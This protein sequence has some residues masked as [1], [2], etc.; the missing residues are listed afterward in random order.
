MSDLSF[1]QVH[2]DFHTTELIDGVGSR[3]SKEDFQNALKCG[4][5]DSVTLFSKCHHGWS[6]HP[7][8]A[9]AMHPALDFDLLGAQIDAC[10]ELGIR[11][12][13]Y[14]SAGFDHKTCIAHPD[15]MCVD[16]VE[17]IGEPIPQILEHYYRLCF[18]S[19]YLDMLVAQVEEV[20]KKYNCDEIFLDIVGIHPCYCSYCRKILEER[21]KSLYDTEAVMQL[22]EETFYRYTERI[23]N[24]ID[25]HK[26]GLPVFHNS[27]HIR[28]GNRRLAYCNTHLEIES[29]PTGGWG[30][31]HFPLSASY[32]G[33]LG[34]DYIGMTGKFHTTW[35]DFGGYKHPNALKYETS[36]CLANGAGCSIGDQ[37]HPLGMMDKATYRLIGEAYADVEK[38]E[39]YCQDVRRVADIGVLSSEACKAIDAGLLNSNSYPDIGA[40][41]MLT[42]GHYLYEF[43]DMEAD[44]SRYKILVLPDDIQAVGQLE[45]KLKAFVK[46][47]GKLL[48][49][50]KS[51]LDSDNRFTFDFGADFIKKSELSP[52]YLHPLFDTPPFGGA[53]FVVYGDHFDIEVSTGKVLAERSDPYFKRENGNFCSHQHTPFDPNKRAPAIVKGKDGIY[54]SFSIFSDYAKYGRLILRIVFCYMLD[55]LL[56]ENKTL[57]M[58][59]FSEKGI[60]TLMKRNGKNDLFQHVLYA[61]TFR[62]GESIDV[63]ESLPTVTGVEA[64]LKLEKA[65]I[66]V[67]CVPQNQDISFRYD[68]RVLHYTIPK[69]SCHQIVEIIY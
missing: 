5:I 67:K 36:L 11:T 2:L 30:Y 31:D 51:A 24:A 9:N 14:L 34:M 41:R 12:P 43:I 52:S 39:P 68:N 6:Y 29:L 59:N 62:A 54:C 48:A 60:V 69:F 27:G 16:S 45:D 21:G 7:S 32:A 4:H 25:W 63:I 13:V 55:L 15:W 10:K 1:R 3:F 33:T 26:P 37:L 50:G 56:G 46:T 8:E 28:R 66:S 65:P 18:N 23:R 58:S 22:A 64:S 44:F 42:E 57:Q 40:N 49:T 20:V 47:G 19:P 53:D 38:K 61:P 17:K 35:G